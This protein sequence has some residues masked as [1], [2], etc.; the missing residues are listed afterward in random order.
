MK[1][2]EEPNSFG[3][4]YIHVPFCHRACSYCDFY[5]SVQ[6]KYIP[7]FLTALLKE[8]KIQKNFFK[9]GEKIRTLYLGGGTPSILSIN[10]LELLFKTIHQNF[11]NL[12]LKEI[13]IEANPEDITQEKLC[14]WSELG[15]NRISLG[16]QSVHEEE[17]LFMKRNHSVSQVFHAMELIKS[18]GIKNYSVDI[19]YGIPNSNLKKLEAT[20]NQL[21][22]FEPTH[23]SC[24]ALTIE[25]KTL[26]DYQWKKGFFD[27]EEEKYL[28]EYHFIVEYLIERGYLRYELSN[29]CLPN[30]Q[31]IHNSA[32]W[33]HSPYLGLGPSAH[34][35]DG[36]AR[37]SNISNLHKYAEKILQNEKPISFY[38]ILTLEQIQIEKLMFKIRQNLG[39]DINEIQPKIIEDWKKHF[40]IE[41][42]ENKVFFTNKGLML[43]D[44]LILQLV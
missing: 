42:K 20:L 35:F 18:S 10:D 23:F 31:A 33:K 41:E 15:I 37:Y 6:K 4:I 43:S 7:H 39:I 25:K 38:E 29:F 12:D 11:V 14:F 36:Y 5:F 34:S 21:I 19:I 16:V 44:S 3:G 9:K 2:E 26:L 17:L 13:T 32:Y 1:A 30:Y 22:N 24:Y 40:Y 28:T 27:V 8:I